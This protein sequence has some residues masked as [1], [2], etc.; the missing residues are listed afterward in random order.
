MDCL[1]K[2]ASPGRVTATLRKVRHGRMINVCASLSCLRDC[3]QDPAH[4]GSVT[5]T[6]RNVMHG[7][8]QPIPPHVS[9]ACAAVIRRALSRHASKRI[10][11]DELANSAW[12]LD[13]AREYQQ[14]LKSKASE[15][16]PCKNH[17]HCS[18]DSSAA[19]QSQAATA[20]YSGEGRAQWQHAA[21]MGAENASCCSCYSRD[22]QKGAC[23]V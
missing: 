8:M 3:L 22:N 15:H 17:A 20:S 12:V 23:N 5:A 16:C 11:L 19:Q 1:Q 7:R 9:S 6:L 10:T 14:G 21:D 13:K 2:P 18:Y 4:P